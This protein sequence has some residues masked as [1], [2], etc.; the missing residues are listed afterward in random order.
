MQKKYNNMSNFEEKIL[1][2]EKAIKNL[3]EIPKLVEVDGILRDGAIKRFE[4]CF[5][6]SWK[7]LKHK[8]TELG[9]EVYSPRNAFVEGVKN[10]FINENTDVKNLIETRNEATHSYDLKLA[11]E[12]FKQIPDFIIIFESI[13]KNLINSKI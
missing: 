1:D 8:L 2:F 6:L 3:K 10:G 12:V 4:L 7:C 9:V 5:D 11:E 13:Y